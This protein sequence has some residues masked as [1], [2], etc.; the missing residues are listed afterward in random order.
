M[1]RIYDIGANVG[2]FTEE[3]T[4]KYPNCEIIV[5]EANPSL[6]ETLSNKFYSNNKITILNNCVTNEDDTSIDFY[7]CEADT[8][9]SASKKWT[10]ESRFADYK[11][12]EP[13][14]IE[15]IS[16]ET[17]IKKYGKADYIKID[18]EGYEKVVISGMSKNLG[19]LSFEWAE[20]LKQ[21]ILESL[22]HSNSI[23]YTKYYISYNDSYTFIP[24]QFFSFDYLINEVDKLNESRKVKWGMIFAK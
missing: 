13:I 18:V 21:D 3:N 19:L 22:N 17:L 7:I 12:R 8:I 14:K 24:E 15:G 2:K 10:T 20:E 11:Y 4:I 6:F 1:E 16:I 23:G 5:I 9:S